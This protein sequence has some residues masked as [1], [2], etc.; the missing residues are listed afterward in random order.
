MKIK[1]IFHLPVFLT[2]VFVFFAIIS[3]ACS[4]IFAATS[5]QLSDY[6]GMC[7]DADKSPNP[8]TVDGD[9]YVYLH[10]C[11]AGETPG[12]SAFSSFNGNII[13][14]CG[15][16]CSEWSVCNSNGY[17]SCLTVQQLPSNLIC[18]NAAQSPMM[19]ACD[20]VLPVPAVPCTGYTYGEWSGCADG[21]QSRT[22]VSSIPSGCAATA[23]GSAVPETSRKCTVCTYDC[24][25]WS[26]CVLGI[27]TRV[28]A[29]V[30]AG[31]VPP[32]DM[33]LIPALRQTCANDASVCTSYAY[34]DWGACGSAGIQ[35]QT[36][37][38]R[39]PA[40]CVL[41][42]GIPET[43]IQTCTYR[44]PC[45]YSYGLWSTTCDASGFRTR[46][47][48]AAPAGC[49]PEIAP[50]IKEPCAA[51]TVACA[52]YTYTDWSACSGDGKQE[53]SILAKLPAGCNDTGSALLAR[54]CIYP[55]PCV[56]YVYS[57]WGAC[58]SAG[59]Q[60]RKIISSSPAGCAAGPEPILEKDC[61]PPAVAVPSPASCVYGYSEW[62]N[63]NSAG[64]QNRKLVSILPQNCA[65]KEPPVLEQS[66]NYL[67]PAISGTAEANL[68]E[69]QTAG[70]NAAA[71]PKKPCFYS[72]S[73]W[74]ACVSK[75]QFRMVVSKSP[76]DCDEAIAPELA[77][78]C[79]ESPLALPAQ[80]SAAPSAAPQSV[81][82]VLPSEAMPKNFN[83]RTD[84][85]WQQY[86]FG[87]QICQ[88][89]NKCG[90]DAD[91]DNDGMSNNDEYRFGTNPN[92]PDTDR[93]G[94]VDADEIQSGRNPLAAAT[95]TSS[96]AIIYENPKETG[97]AAGKIY[98]V[99]NVEMIQSGAGKKEL[100]ITGKALPNSYVTIYIFSDPVVL[101]VKTDS[102]GNW[103]YI[104]DK[105][106]ED[107]SHEVYVAVNDNRGKVV[108]KSEPL[109]FVQTAEAATAVYPAPIV[110]E[111]RAPAPTKSR[112]WEGYFIFFGAGLGGLF[113]ALA[114]IGLARNI[115][116]TK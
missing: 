109:P 75:R 83:G 24:G 26:A 60:I 106:M 10:Y 3:F 35:K 30:P 82:A 113:L 112:L 90:G 70:G 72:Y 19:R 76:L 1:T 34:G 94:R 6:P 12:N 101:T 28:C 102:E 55:A 85:A 44:V 61:I 64:R 39:V 37:T 63:C 84:G 73:A 43:K 77:R 46:P 93:D 4:L 87:A 18:S 114:A 78:D 65:Q 21:T 68:N 80:S 11:N 69:N 7:L 88:N 95:A 66:C 40:D 23:S 31:C 89:E 99:S 108:A 38:Q 45:I 79:A 47:Y 15:Y 62:G 57:N 53:R 8:Q 32:L 54:P 97:Q 91:P 71:E 105:P 59:K 49:S 92:S 50:V 51:G 107:G 98:Q 27:K 58:D 103:S 104:L 9:L 20:A 74:G 17:Q 52:A 96:D 81:L 33:T 36:I 41:P 110:T 48:T 42:D 22:V 67:R 100:K 111:E 56:S 16:A 29:A 86:Y 13:F 115:G 116:K 5:S 25:V 2:I 14:V